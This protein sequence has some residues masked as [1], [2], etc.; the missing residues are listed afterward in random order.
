MDLHVT[1]ENSMLTTYICTVQSGVTGK[2]KEDE[3]MG[4]FEDPWE[5]EFEEESVDEGMAKKNTLVLYL[6]CGAHRL[7]QPMSS[8][9]AH[10][11]HRHERGRRRREWRRPNGRG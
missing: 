4:E 7:A 2:S 3:D 11:V 6:R 1:T 5:D 10:R 9:L 8:S